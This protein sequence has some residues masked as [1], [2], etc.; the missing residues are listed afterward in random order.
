M[1]ASGWSLFKGRNLCGAYNQNFLWRYKSI[2]VM[3]NHRAAMWCWLQHVDPQQ[4]HSLFHMDWHNDALQSRL[5]DWLKHCPKSTERLSIEDYLQ[6]DYP[7]EDLGPG[8][9]SLLFQWDNYLSIYLARY[10]AS[11][12]Q[13]CVLTHGDGDE[14]N[15]IHNCGDLWDV[16]ANIDYWL[17]PTN[18]P[19][20]ANIDLDYF[21]WHD[22][23]RPGL[24]VSD[25]Y[26]RRCFAAIK[27]RIDDGTIAVTTIALTPDEGITGGWAPAESV[28]THVLE[29][30][31]IEF[32]L[33]TGS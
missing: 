24:M 2:Y 5:E 19:W 16:P 13:F 32:K 20:I 6:C 1:T 14:P 18:R 30:L 9:R 22:E 7:L 8:R 11:L 26:L 25:E 3:D 17:E 31:G 27:A 29:A 15:Y 28:A 12:E 10:P 4:P 21:F 33:P 23:E